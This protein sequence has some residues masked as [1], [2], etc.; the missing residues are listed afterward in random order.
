MKRKTVKVKNLVKF[1]NKFNKE[2]ADALKEHREAYNTLLENILLSANSYQ[3]FQYLSKDDLTGDAMSVGI[4]FNE[5]GTVM[6]NDTD[7]TRVEYHYT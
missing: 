7:E 2:S 6:Y 3:G 5:D 4:R 1:V